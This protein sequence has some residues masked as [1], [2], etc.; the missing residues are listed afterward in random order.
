MDSIG[1]C[2]LNIFGE[3]STVPRRLV[4]GVRFGAL[5]QC[6]TALPATARC[7]T[8]GFRISKLQ[9]ACSS[10]SRARSC[11][12]VQCELN[13]SWIWL[14]VGSFWES[15][16]HF[17][18]D[19]FE[20]FRFGCVAVCRNSVRVFV[21]NFSCTGCCRIDNGTPFVLNPVEFR[22]RGIDVPGTNVPRWKRTLRNSLLTL[23]CTAIRSWFR[24]R[25]FSFRTLPYLPFGPHALSLVHAIATSL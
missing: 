19:G 1:V 15:W 22:T 2:C 12:S 5:H 18:S 11:F 21:G 20:V 6:K 3:Y 24:L 4:Q 7:R 25:G 10:F 13:T 8:N 23:T 14:Q 9:F 16:N 17:C